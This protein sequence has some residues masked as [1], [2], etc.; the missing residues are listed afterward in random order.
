LIKEESNADTHCNS[1]K[2]LEPFESIF[3]DILV[4]STD[5]PQIRHEQKATYNLCC[6]SPIFYPKDPSH[7]V[8][9]VIESQ[10][11]L[12]YQSLNNL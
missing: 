3:D 10:K 12:R 9:A 6:R 1:I 5:M 4:N 8:K 2:D 11:H 7:L